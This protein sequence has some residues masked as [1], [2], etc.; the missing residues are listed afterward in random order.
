MY[1]EIKKNTLIHGSETSHI[2]N[3]LN[4]VQFKIIHVI[5]FNVKQYLKESLHP[6]MHIL[7]TNKG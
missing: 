3:L 4:K 7:R 2:E 1:L 6:L 5:T